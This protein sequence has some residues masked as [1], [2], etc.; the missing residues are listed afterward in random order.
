MNKKDLK[1]L[2]R[3]Y[4][5]SLNGASGATIITNYGKMRDYTDKLNKDE[6]GEELCILCQLF[7]IYQALRA[8]EKEKV[9]LKGCSTDWNSRAIAKGYEL[10]KECERLYRERGLCQ[11]Y[12][13]REMSLCVLAH[14]ESSLAT[15]LCLYNLFFT[16]GAMDEEDLM[17][18]KDLLSDDVM[19]KE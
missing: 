18:L 5:K 15:Q 11:D 6:L 8:V 4:T 13:D 17:K 2:L 14:T 10:Y 7:T 9:S 12:E 3:R 16:R 19:P 1:E